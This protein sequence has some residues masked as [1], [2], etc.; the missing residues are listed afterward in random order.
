MKAFP[1]PNFGSP[2]AVV[3]N[4]LASPNLSEDHFR[5]WIAR[6]DQSR[7]AERAPVLPLRP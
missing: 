2:D 3:N 6:V 7:R 5:N 1:A 4:F